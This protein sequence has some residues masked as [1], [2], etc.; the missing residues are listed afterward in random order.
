MQVEPPLIS[1]IKINNDE[2][3]DKYFVQIKLRRDPTS[4]NLDLYELKMALFDNGDHEELFL[5]IRNFNMYIE[6]SGTLRPGEKV[7]YLCML[8]HG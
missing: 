2:K 6:A 4:E 3:L 1:L 5:F 7:Q 8:V